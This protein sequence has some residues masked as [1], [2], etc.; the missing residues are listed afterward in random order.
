MA[1]VENRPT[2]D[3]DRRKLAEAFAASQ[4]R[5]E[6]LWLAYFSLGG[7]AGR[8]EVE[9]YLT[10]LMPMSAHNHNI[11]AQAVNERLAQHPPPPRAPYRLPDERAQEPRQTDGG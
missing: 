6:E 11:L 10:G 1:L 2:P 3:E 9:G 8:F 5:M 4:M 7:N